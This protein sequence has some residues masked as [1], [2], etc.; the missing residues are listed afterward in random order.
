MKECWSSLS[1]ELI[2]ES[3]RFCGISVN[4]DGS[5]GTEI[6]CLKA[7]EVAPWAAL[8]IPDFTR[9]LLQEDESNEEDP[10]A[11]VDEEDKEEVEQNKLVIYTDSD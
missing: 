1:T 6:Y 7:G 11:S 10:F 5:E 4:V 2:Q 9:K 8:V 3:F